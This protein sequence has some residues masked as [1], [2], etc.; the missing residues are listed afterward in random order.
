MTKKG[1]T[2]IIVPRH[3]QVVLK[4]EAEAQGISIANYIAELQSNIRSIRGLVSDSSSINTVD[5]TMK[6]DQSGVNGEKTMLRRGFP[7]GFTGKKYENKDFLRLFL[8]FK[9]YHSFISRHSGLSILKSSYPFPIPF[10][11]KRFEYLAGISPEKILINH[12]PTLRKTI[13]YKS[14]IGNI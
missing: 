9:H 10:I 6:T 11:L 5:N 1:Y 3:L 14:V 8:I 7:H 4:K 12:K 2:H 13:K